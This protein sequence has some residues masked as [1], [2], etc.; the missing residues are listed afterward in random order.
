MRGSHGLPP[1]LLGPIGKRSRRQ[2]VRTHV[3]SGRMSNTRPKGSEARCSTVS[4]LFRYLPR[5]GGLL[6]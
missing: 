5:A 4:R 6:C 3:D 2:T 1:S